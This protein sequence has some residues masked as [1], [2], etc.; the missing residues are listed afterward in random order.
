ML[1]HG[2]PGH[3]INT[4]SG[5]GG[6]EPLPDQ[7]VYASSKSAV[8][9][10]TEC[11][12]AQLAAESDRVRAMLFYPAGGLLDT[13]IWT[14]DRNRPADLARETPVAGEPQ[15]LEKF[16]TMARKAGFEL[17]V[18]DLDELAQSLLRD[19]RAGRFV[20]MLGL[21]QAGQTLARRAQRIG[22]GELPQEP[23]R[24]MMI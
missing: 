22:A 23:S 19:I 3:V 14:C 17:P 11:L 7:A 1:A 16:R 9:I 20:S 2:E 12:G 21:E 18:Q 13:G 24:G 15:T 8:S 4:S 6:I 5:N 10:V